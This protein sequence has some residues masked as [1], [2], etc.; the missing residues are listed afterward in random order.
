MRVMA[1]EDHGIEHLSLGE[2]PVPEPRRGEVVVRLRAAALNY[3]DLEIARGT[4]H[5]RF[6][7]PLV[8]LSDGVGEVVAVGDEVRRVKAGDRVAGTFWQ[9]WTG[10]DFDPSSQAQQLGGPLDGMLSEYV[11]LD[12]EG[13]VVLPDAIGDEDAAALPCAAV[14]AWQA[15][16]TEG[17]IKAGDSVLVQ[18]TGGVS[19]FAL[20]F[21]AMTGAHVVATSSSD[22]KLERAKAL[23]AAATVNYRTHPD[24]AAEVLRLTGGRGVDH[25]VEVGGPGSFAQSLKAIRPGGQINVIGYVGGAEGMI[26]PLDIF[27]R[28]ATV[29]GIPVGSRQSFEALLRALVATGTRPVIDRV[30][31]WTEAR[32]AL[33]H[34][35]SGH[36]V[37][38]VVL[39]F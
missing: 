35:E 8:P 22:A 28:R 10:G 3:R 39:R 34:L 26:N 36:H 5:T 13:V 19:I 38:K 33:K 30:F 6:P 4:Y 32:Q 37:G 14:T 23:G 2:R 12:A 1:I 9:C 15:L 25:V 18:G 27:R 20:Q 16:V 29:R 24:W 11:R 21:A 31:A 17:R 7:L